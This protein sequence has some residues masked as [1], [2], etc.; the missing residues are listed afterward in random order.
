VAIDGVQIPRGTPIIKVRHRLEGAIGTPVSLT[1]RHGDGGVQTAQLTRIENPQ[2][3]AA[4]ALGLS[5]GVLRVFFPALELILM[6]VFVGIGLLIASRRFDD[7]WLLFLSVTLIMAAPTFSY[8]LPLLW[9]VHPEWSWLINLIGPLSTACILPI[10]F[11]FPDGRFVPRWTALPAALWVVWNLAQYL[12]PNSAITLASGPTGLQT[13]VYLLCYCLGIWAQ[14]HRFRH[15]SSP[16]QRQQTKWI[17]FGFTFAVAAFYAWE[18]LFTLVPQIREPGRIWI[19]IWLVGR[20]IY[21]AALV[22]T[23]VSIAIAMLRY[24]L[25]DIDVIIKK[26]LVYGLLTTVLGLIYVGSVLLLQRLIEP[27]VGQSSLAVAGS[28]LLVAALFRPVR[29]NIQ[30]GVD[31]RFYRARY[32][33]DRIVSTFRH[34]TRDEIDLDHLTAT[35]VDVVHETVQPASVSLWLR[36]P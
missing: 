16:L 20:P 1:V 4:D 36:E 29:G 10:F 3:R 12:Y 25:W 33:A 23:P 5:T 13:L 7:W 11:L 24:R 35:L 9:Q 34:T 26:A 32:D 21:V 22:M 31:R 18:I 2:G 27:L 17:V 14:V 28:T 30:T 8:S 15:V 6:A 19:S